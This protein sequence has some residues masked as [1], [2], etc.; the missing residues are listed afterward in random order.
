M[1]EGVKSEAS[2]FEAAIAALGENDGTEKQVLQEALKGA[3]KAAQDV[4]C[5]S[6]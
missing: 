6:S 5:V 1:A 2:R 3:R 4:Q